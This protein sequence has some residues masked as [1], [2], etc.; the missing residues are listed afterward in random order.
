[1]IATAQPGLLIRRGQQCF[2]FCPR[3]EVYRSFDVSLALDRQDA[4]GQRAESGF[5]Q[6]DIMKEG[7]DGSQTHIATA[8]AHTTVFFQ[9]IKKAA[10]KGGIQVLHG[11]DGWR[12]LQ[13]PMGKA[14]Q[15][16]ESI[17]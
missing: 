15:E 9:M 5:L 12:L 16:A 3:E 6:G 2:S 1:V 17:R 11:Q 10:H 8:C 13:I 4:L 14:D 7:M